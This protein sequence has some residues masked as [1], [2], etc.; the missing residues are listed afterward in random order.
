MSELELL[1]KRE[2]NGKELRC[3]AS[4]PAL[5][6][7][8]VDSTTI[9]I[10]CKLHLSAFSLARK[11]LHTLSV[12]SLRNKT[13]TLTRISFY[14]YHIFLFV[15][16]SC[17]TFGAPKSHPSRVAHTGLSRRP[18]RRWIRLFAVLSL[19]LLLL[20]FLPKPTVETLSFLSFS[21]PFLHCV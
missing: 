5:E 4:N 2:D 3:E 21:S 18:I 10:E 14:F 6:G 15:V 7:N 16:C 19:F 9:R 17:L 8:L 11:H 20:F 13:I 12:R 1:A